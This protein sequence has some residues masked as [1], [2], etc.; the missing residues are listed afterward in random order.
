MRGGELTDKEW[1]WLTLLLPPQKPESIT[2][3]ATT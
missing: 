1:K 3:L 2:A